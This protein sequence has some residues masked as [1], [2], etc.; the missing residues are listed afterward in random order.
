M[1]ED[2]ALVGAVDFPKRPDTND[3][4]CVDPCCFDITAVESKVHFIRSAVAITLSRETQRPVWKRDADKYERGIGRSGCESRNLPD[5]RYW[6][7]RSYQSELVVKLA[8]IRCR[9]A[10]WW[11]YSRVWFRIR[12]RRW[13]ARPTAAATT[14]SNDRGRA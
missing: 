3:F 4:H 8:S 2:D 6:I 9:S 10:C 14:A 5:K 7:W 1:L 11:Q 12:S 13:R